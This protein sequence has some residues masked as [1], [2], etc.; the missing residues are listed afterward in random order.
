MRKLGA[1][2]EAPQ[3]VVRLPRMLLN[4]LKRRARAEGD[5]PSVIVREALEA[6][7]KP[8]GKRRK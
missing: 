5:K 3:I 1:K 8:S 4:Q 7:L 2:G 6:F